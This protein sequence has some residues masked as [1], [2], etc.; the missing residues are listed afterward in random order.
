[1]LVEI[2]CSRDLPYTLELPISCGRC[3]QLT[4]LPLGR[5]QLALACRN[6]CRCVQ[7]DSIIARPSSREV[8]V[9]P[10]FPHRCVCKARPG[11]WRGRAAHRTFGMLGH[12]HVFLQA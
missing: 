8:A 6:T 5:L 11:F 1:M 4:E 9:A 10:L 7:G 3:F 2:L 12:F